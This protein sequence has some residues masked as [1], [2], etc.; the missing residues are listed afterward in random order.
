[1]VAVAVGAADVVEIGAL[2]LVGTA[3]GM[4]QPLA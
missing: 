4:E 2:V 1:M 3:E